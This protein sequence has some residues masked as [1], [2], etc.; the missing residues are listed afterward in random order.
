MR[1]AR[2]ALILGDGDGRFTARLL[3][4][5]SE[6]RIDAVDASPAMLAALKRRAGKGADR[7]RCI[8]ADART[9]TPSPGASYDLVL[10]HFFLD[11]LTTEEVAELA[12]RV[13]PVVTRQGAWIVSEFAV[14]SHRGRLPARFVVGFLYRAFG[15]MTGLRIRRLPDHTRA[16]RSPGFSLLQRR[17]WLLGLLV[18]EYWSHVSGPV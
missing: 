17:T 1:S 16:L 7:V 13:T 9:W 6:I 5:N 18:S 8:V 4:E 12:A 11:C 2:R 10:T 3:K 14:P 15:W